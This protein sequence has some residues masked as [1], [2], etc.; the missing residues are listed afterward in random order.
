MGTVRGL[1]IVILGGPHSETKQG[2][3]VE[4]IQYQQYQQT[5]KHTNQATPQ[6]LNL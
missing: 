2:L 6:Y 1:Q 3:K 5:T 4:E